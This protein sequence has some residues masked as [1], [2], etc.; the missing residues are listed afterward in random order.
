ME[1]RY[2]KVMSHIEITPEICDRILNNINN[3]D[4]DKKSGKTAYFP[5]YN[6]YLSIAACLVILLASAFIIKNMIVV[7]DEPPIEAVPGILECSSMKELSK[8]MGFAVKEIQD[9]PFEVESVQ[10]T[11]YVGN[12]AQIQYTGLKNTVMLRMAAGSDDISGD[13]T[14][15]ASIKKDGNVILKGNDNQYML[16]IWQKDGYSYALRFDIAV[17]QQEI[18]AAVQSVK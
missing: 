10:Y 17:S 16:A 9:V 2:D 7:P 5:K 13:Y 6:K 18:T 1:N 3:L 15:Y 14:E 11:A 12:L 4:L 8:A